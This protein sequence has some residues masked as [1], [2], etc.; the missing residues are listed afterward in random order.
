MHFPE[1]SIAALCHARVHRLRQAASNV[2]GRFE[3]LAAD[4]TSVSPAPPSRAALVSY[5]T[6]SGLSM[7]LGYMTLP[8]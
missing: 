4:S 8:G 6:P 1:N 7:R 2:M 3:R 5:E